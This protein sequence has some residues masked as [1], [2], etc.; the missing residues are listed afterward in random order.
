MKKGSFV[1]IHEENS[2]MVNKYEKDWIKDDREN[3]QCS[4]KAKLVITTTL[5]L[6]EVLRVSH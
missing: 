6:N 2:V 4:L 3:V 5:D 1:P